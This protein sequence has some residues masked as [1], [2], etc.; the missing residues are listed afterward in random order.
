MTRRSIFL[1]ALFAPLLRALP[2]GVLQQAILPAGGSPATAFRFYSWQAGVWPDRSAR[3]LSIDIEPFQPCT[4]SIQIDRE[5][6]ASIDVQPGRQQ[7]SLPLSV[8]MRQGARL[9][10]ETRDLPAVRWSVPR[11]SL[12]R[13]V[14]S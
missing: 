13:R 8:I 11:V 2:P 14:G 6:V 7:I 10:V 5:T 1:S 12:G 4:L 3:E 9:T